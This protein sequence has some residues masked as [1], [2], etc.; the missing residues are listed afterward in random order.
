MIDAT[1]FVATILVDHRT[2]VRILIDFFPFS[3]SFFSF[4]FRFKKRCHTFKWF[5]VRIV[6]ESRMIRLDFYSERLRFFMYIKLFI[7]R[8][9]QS[10]TDVKSRQWTSIYLSLFNSRCAIAVYSDNSTFMIIDEN[11]LFFKSFD[12]HLR[13]L[14]NQ[15]LLYVSIFFFKSFNF[16]WY[17]LMSIECIMT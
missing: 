1:R 11:F 14:F 9:N 3:S 5:R 10:S 12:N 2:S 6:Y 8:M 15:I 7:T 4:F 17:F 16:S 13:M